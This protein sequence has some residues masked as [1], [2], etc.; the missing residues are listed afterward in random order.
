MDGFTWPFSIWLS[1][2]AVIP[3]AEESLRIEFF[4]F[5]RNSCIF[6]PMFKSSKISSFR[7]IIIFDFAEYC[8]YVEVYH[9]F[10]IIEMN[11][12]IHY[13][14]GRAER[15]GHLPVIINVFNIN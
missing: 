1:I 10:R 4:C 15:R 7:G 14:R 8:I 11:L 3:A 2:E 6:F 9:I 13:T 12:K 5:K